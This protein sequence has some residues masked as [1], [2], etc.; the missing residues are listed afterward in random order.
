MAKLVH[1]NIHVLR[2]DGKDDEAV[3]FGMFLLHNIALW[4]ERGMVD[5]A[6]ENIKKYAT[7]HPD[8]VVK[9]AAHG[10]ARLHQALDLQTEEP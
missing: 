3:A 9:A 8:F 2:V 4:T 10:A 7:N 6:C 5:R 1:P